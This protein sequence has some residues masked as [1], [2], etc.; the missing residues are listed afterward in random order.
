MRSAARSLWFAGRQSSYSSELK[1]EP[2]VCASK[3]RAVGTCYSG[4]L[5][6][7]WFHKETRR[8]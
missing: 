7:T 3:R 6:L 1:K 8:I 5:S 2:P 4:A